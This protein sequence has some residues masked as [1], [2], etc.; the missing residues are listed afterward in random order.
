MRET[1]DKELDLIEINE[2]E[3][4][5]TECDPELIKQ[6]EKENIDKQAYIDA[7]S[8]SNENAEAFLTKFKDI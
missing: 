4:F 6:L 5:K 8:V 3:K 7:I 2:L 1:T